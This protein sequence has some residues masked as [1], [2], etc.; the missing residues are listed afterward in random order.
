MDHQEGRCGCGCGGAVALRFLPGHNRRN[1]PIRG[2]YRTVG[3]G[4]GKPGRFVHV[5][6]AERALGKPLPEKA[7][8][9]HV[10]GDGENNANRNLVICE[11]QAYHL[12]LHKRQRIVRAG[13]DPDTE[14]ICSHCRQVLPLAAFGRYKT[15]LQNACRP[16]LLEMNMANWRRH[17]VAIA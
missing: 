11:D 1:L 15:G 6:V 13:G 10:D 14:R 3:Q 17:R 4:T 16:C 7:R 2:K 9:H 5:V 12:L 8:I